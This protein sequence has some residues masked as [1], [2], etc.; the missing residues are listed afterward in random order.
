MSDV[1]LHMRALLNLSPV[2]PVF[3][4]ESVDEAVQV[5]QALVRGG[6]P[7]IEV[8]LRTAVAM[9]AIKAIAEHVP[10]ALVGAVTVLD[11]RQMEQVKAGGGALRCRRARPNVCMRRRMRS[12]CRSCPG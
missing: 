2:I 3:T 12:V 8:T 10:G 1:E 11:A 7:V 5:A 9:D 6:L 4:P